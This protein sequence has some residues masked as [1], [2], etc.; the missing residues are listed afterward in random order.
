MKLEE[1][2][3]ISPY[4]FI[5]HGNLNDGLKLMQNNSCT[6]CKRLDCIDESNY[7][8]KNYYKCYKDLR[9]F[10]V[11]TN[12]GNSF[13]LNGLLFD[14]DS[15]P[16][17]KKFK[18]NYFV[19]KTNIQVVIDLINNV[20]GV[21]ESKILNTIEE[22]F[23]VFHDV[24]TTATTVT[25]CAEN[26]INKNKGDTF[27][28]KLQNSENELFDL[29][30]SISLL[31]EHLGMID[32]LVNTNK[33]KYARKKP[34]NVFQL[35]ERFSRLLRNN[36]KKKNLTI[37]WHDSGRVNDIQLY[38]AFQFLPLILIDNAI[39]Y[40]SN[41]R[42]IE[43]GIYEH[44]DSVSVHVSSFGKFVDDSESEKIFEKYY[45]GENSQN[46]EGIGMG[47]WIAKTLCEAHDG[48]IT[49]E[50]NGYGN[51]GQNVFKV[52]IPRLES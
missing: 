34:I 2:K 17:L 29:Y 38:P 31:T 12:N 3:S 14:E 49:Y 9:T 43:I 1:F 48:S 8:D 19:D 40:S 21:I 44:G 42:S 4:P 28:D 50:K 45:R 22:H 41:D 37:N 26:L 13:F 36:T 24:K 20:E 7:E 46:N 11:S 30:N 16:T 47:L 23:S 27:E 15:N 35:F 25:N 51:Y 32:I 18:K 33:V 6:G 5:Y 10:K 39:K 52:H